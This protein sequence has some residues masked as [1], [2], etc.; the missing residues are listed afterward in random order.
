MT[1]VC[2][3]P[4]SPLLAH[5]IMVWLHEIVV[6]VLWEIM[7]EITRFGPEGLMHP[8]LCRRCIGATLILLVLP[9]SSFVEV[10]SD[11]SLLLVPHQ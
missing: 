10:Q 4:Q 6:A 8:A 11:S 2:F 7:N 9:K 3:W 1:V 5:A